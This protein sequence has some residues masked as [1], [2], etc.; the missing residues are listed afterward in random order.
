MNCADYF[1]R[2]DWAILGFAGGVFMTLVVCTLG[3][4]VVLPDLVLKVR[5]RRRG[6]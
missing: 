3:A 5:R 1:S 4:A 2:T 6:P